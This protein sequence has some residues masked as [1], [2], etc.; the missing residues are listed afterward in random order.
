M[1]DGLLEDLNEYLLDKS[2]DLCQSILNEVAID[3]VISD[4]EII[5]VTNFVIGFVPAF[6]SL[7]KSKLVLILKDIWGV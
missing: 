3:K 2:K 6:C 1:E 7:D 4:E 5:R